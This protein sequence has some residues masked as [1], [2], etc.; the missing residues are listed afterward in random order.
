MNEKRAC[1]YFMLIPKYM[2]LFVFFFQDSMLLCKSECA[3]V[4]RKRK[5]KSHP[6]IF[7]C[8]FWLYWNVKLFSNVNVQKDHLGLVKR[9][10]PDF[11]LGDLFLLEVPWLIM[12]YGSWTFGSTLRVWV[13]LER[14]NVIIL[15][16]PNHRNF[17]F[18]LFF[19]VKSL[20]LNL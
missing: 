15:H 4:E 16:L 19:N 8:S 3:D 11:V 7:V 2:Y 14:W 13:S 17:I 5:K 1:T 20:W 18:V 6:C 9:V 12:P 10:F